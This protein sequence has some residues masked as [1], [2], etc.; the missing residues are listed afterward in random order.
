MTHGLLK[1]SAKNGPIFK[2]QFAIFCTL[3]LKFKLGVKFYKE[4]LKFGHFQKWKQFR[5]R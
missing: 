5:T 4:I 1:K 3:K 2:I